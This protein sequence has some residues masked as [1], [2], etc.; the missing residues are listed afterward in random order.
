MPDSQKESVLSQA[1]KPFAIKE[2]GD[3]PLLT[4]DIPNG[5]T[6][7]SP[8]ATGGLTRDPIFE[9]VASFPQQMLGHKHLLNIQTDN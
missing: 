9:G 5:G 4:Q 7:L 3:Q 2:P 1:Q 6:S 8:L